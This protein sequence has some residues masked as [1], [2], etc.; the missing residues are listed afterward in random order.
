MVQFL[1]LQPA[2]LQNRVTGAV[3]TTTEY[4]LLKSI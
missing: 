3:D 1:F 4:I 2:V